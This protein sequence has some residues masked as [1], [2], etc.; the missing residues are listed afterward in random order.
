MGD[1]QPTEPHQRGYF[2]LILES[3]QYQDQFSVNTCGLNP[4]SDS[5]SASGANWIILHC[6]YAV[7][8]V[9]GK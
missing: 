5:I 2:I 4:S 7:L 3:Q 1:V 9:T 8:S 6:Y